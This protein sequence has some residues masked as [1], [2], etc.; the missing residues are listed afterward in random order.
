VSYGCAKFSKKSGAHRS[1]RVKC[2][3]I[4]ILCKWDIYS[5]ETK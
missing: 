3:Y 5:K 4:E 2:N 1:K